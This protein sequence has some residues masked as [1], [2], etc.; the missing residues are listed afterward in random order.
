[1]GLLAPVWARV[2]PNGAMAAAAGGCRT[3][4]QSRVAQRVPNLQLDTQQRGKDE[5]K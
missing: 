3:V 1:M 5:P 2:Q 4:L